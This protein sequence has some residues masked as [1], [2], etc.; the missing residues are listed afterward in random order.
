VEEHVGNFQRALTDGE[1]N[2]SIPGG[3][4]IRQFS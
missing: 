4:L 3:K 2:L 1:L